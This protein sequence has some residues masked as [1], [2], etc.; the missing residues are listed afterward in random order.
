MKIAVTG[1]SRG[2]GKAIVDLL[3]DEGHEI[4]GL[5]RGCGYDI[6]DTNLI[7]EAVEPNDV[8]I[9]N[10][11]DGFHQVLLLDAI[12]RLWK[13][14]P[15]LIIN[16]SSNAPDYWPAWNNGYSTEKAALDS[17]ALR[18]GM[19][20]NLCRVTNVRPG[21]IDTRRV[22]GVKDVPKLNPSEVA[23]IV[24]FIINLPREVTIREL[25]VEPR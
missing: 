12:Y 17:A 24:S 15:N 5:S 16:I 21:Y 18:L 13:D 6:K 1:H 20:S 7:A 9:N 23:K 11:H 10:A 22:A 3:I 4:L 14:R 25:T 2:V 19:S 8:F